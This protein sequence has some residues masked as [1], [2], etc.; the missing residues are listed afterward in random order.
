MTDTSKMTLQEFDAKVKQLSLGRVIPFTKATVV[1]RSSGMDIVTFHTDIA[2]TCYNPK[3]SVALQSDFMTY[4]QKDTGA[5]WVRDTFGIEPE[6]IDT[7]K[8]II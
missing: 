6:V 8:G 3:G 7:T 4:Q 1:V 5:Q 2:S